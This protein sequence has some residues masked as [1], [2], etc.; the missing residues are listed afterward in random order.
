MVEI[1]LIK[2]EFQTFHCLLNVDYTFCFIMEKGRVIYN[3]MEKVFDGILY[4]TMFQTG[5]AN[6]EVEWLLG[7]LDNDLI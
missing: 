4:S 1:I 2:D 7:Q 3:L 6:R 5:V